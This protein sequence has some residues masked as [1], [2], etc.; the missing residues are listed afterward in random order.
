MDNHR[1]A[2]LD[3][4]TSDSG[5]DLVSKDNTKP[6]ASGLSNQVNELVK[7]LS[8][9]SRCFTQVGRFRELLKDTMS[10]IYDKQTSK[11]A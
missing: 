10:L 6:E 8:P 11:P 7:G 4:V 2:V 5:W 1:V 3:G 9:S